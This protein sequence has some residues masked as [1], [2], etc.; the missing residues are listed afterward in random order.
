[1]PSRH[2]A[3]GLLPGSPGFAPC[4]SACAPRCSETASW[5]P[6]L[7]PCCSAFAPCC[8]GFAPCCTGT[9]SWSPGRTPWCSASE[10]NQRACAPFGE[11]PNRPEARLNGRERPPHRPKWRLFR[12]ANRC[13]PFRG[14]HW[15]DDANLDPGKAIAAGCVVMARQL[16]MG[17]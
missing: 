2:V 6:G 7:A 8:S 1:M 10:R 16:A 12:P 13:H 3:P 14:I 9:A 4:S 17:I 5:F 11:R 15:L